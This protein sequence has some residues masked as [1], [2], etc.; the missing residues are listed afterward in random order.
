MVFD[1]GDSGLTYEEVDLIDLWVCF[2]MDSGRHYLPGRCPRCG[3]MLGPLGRSFVQGR[4]FFLICLECG[5]SLGFDVDMILRE[6]VKYGYREY[7]DAV[8]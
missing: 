8:G 5:A 7:L 6:C 2:M 3:F 1:P 4:V